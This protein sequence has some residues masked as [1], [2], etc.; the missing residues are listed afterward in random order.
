MSGTEVRKKKKKKGRAFLNFIGNFFLIIISGVFFG[1][2]GLLLAGYVLPHQYVARTKMVFESNNGG[3]A[4]EAEFSDFIT[5]DAV[6]NQVITDTNA[7]YTY[8]ELKDRI[9]S[10]SG[11]RRNEYV[12]SVWATDPYEVRDLLLTI[13]NR[14]EKVAKEFYGVS[15]VVITE[16]AEVPEKMMSPDYRMCGIIGCGIGIFL[17]ILVLLLSGPNERV[18]YKA[19]DVEKYLE[20]NCLGEIPVSAVVKNKRKK[21]A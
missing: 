2:L 9:H 21:E 13:R 19:E 11:E 18:I 15:E 14:A 10:G 5:G 16:E 12:F 1:M 8:Q 6:L 20:M 7:G 3:F 17:C 4:D